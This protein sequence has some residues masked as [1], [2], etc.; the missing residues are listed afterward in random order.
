MEKRYLI[1]NKVYGSELEYLEPFDIDAEEHNDL[2]QQSL[3]ELAC[4]EGELDKIYEYIGIIYDSKCY[5]ITSI[6]TVKD[7]KVYFK[8]VESESNEAIINDIKKCLY[9]SAKKIELENGFNIV[10]QFE[11][12]AKELLKQFT[13][14]RK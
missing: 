9:E 1:N 14:T 11:E 2:W 7:C 6:T 4:D 13:I 12:Q 5:D 8:E 3:T 10:I